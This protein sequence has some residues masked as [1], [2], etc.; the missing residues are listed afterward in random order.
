[1]EINELLKKVRRI[2]IRSR[3]LSNNLFA[4]HYHSAFKGRGMSF[5]EVREYQYGDDIRS[6]DW[7]VTARF[8]HPFVKIYEE[9]RE[10]TV[11]VLADLSGSSQFASQ[12]ELKRELIAQLAAT[13]AFSALQNNDKIGLLIFTDKVEKYIAP[14]KGRQQA[15]RIIRELLEFESDSKGTSITNA[16]RFFTQVIKKRCIGFI[17]SDFIDVDSNGKLQFEDSLKIASRKHDLIA[18][19]VIDQLETR[20]TGEGLVRFSDP[21]TG[22]IRVIDLSDTAMKN[23]FQRLYNTFEQN[24]SSLL[25]KNKVDSAQL[26]TGQ[27]FVQPLLRLF[28]ER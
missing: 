18:L 25:A 3:G 27:D 5:S 21:E 7:N 16:L 22:Q 11:M 17:I 10:L 26:F 8:N 28:N 20:L 6:I 13:L 4:G 9:E 2:E 24:L 1:V 19:K 12:G 15:L 23:A 14:A